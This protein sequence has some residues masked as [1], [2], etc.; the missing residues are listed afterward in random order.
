MRLI[1]ATLV[2][3]ALATPAFGQS[4]QSGLKTAKG[5]PV[6]SLDDVRSVSPALARVASV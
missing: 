2:S 5:T 4:D 6:L 1:A 3:F